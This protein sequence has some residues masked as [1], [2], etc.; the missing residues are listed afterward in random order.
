MRIGIVNDVRAACEALR[1]VVD[2]LRGHE[3]AWTAAD[4]AE[5]VAMARRDPADLVLMDLSLPVLD[6]WEATRRIKTDART[7]HI[8]VMALTGQDGANELQR[9]G[10]PKLQAVRQA[11]QQFGLWTAAFEAARP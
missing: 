2:S 1:R 11:A 4:G 9:A 6:G 3:V 8:P 7:A 5:A 10:L